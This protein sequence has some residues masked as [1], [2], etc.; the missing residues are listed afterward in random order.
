MKLLLSTLPVY[1]LVTFSISA[2]AKL[3][4][5]DA[6]LQR[7]AI[8]CDPAWRVVSK[9]LRALFKGCSDAARSSTRAAF[10]DCF[11]GACDGSLT[12]QE[13][14]DRDENALL[15]SISRTLSEKA[16]RYKVSKADMIQAAAALAIQSCRGPRLRFLAGRADAT[17]P[18]AAG[19]MPTADADDATQLRLF[20]AR[21]FGAEELVALVGA[22]SAARL[23]Q[24]LGLDTTPDRLDSTVFYAQTRDER[25]PSILGSDAALAA[26]NGTR[27]A[28]NRFAASQGAWQVAFVAA[29]SKMTTLGNNVKNLTDC[30]VYLY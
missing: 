27:R 10:H 28:W 3:N 2:A 15:V 21:G 14:L 30:S 7:R 24:G 19:Q 12:L 13:E 20:G 9:D 1:L 4:D 16:T 5:A 22:H 25:A 6:G 29:M 17:Q 23:Q 11:P 8:R 26:G 18:N